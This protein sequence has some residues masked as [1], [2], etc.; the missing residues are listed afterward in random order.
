M[1]GLMYHLFSSTSLLSLGLFHLVSSA[2]SHLKSPQ[3]Y[4]ARPYH[5]LPF[6]DHHHRPFVRNLQLY[7]LV[8]FLL[9]AAAI[10]AVS[11]STY[12][13]L[14]KGHS[15]V[16]RFTSL[17][18]SA[19]LLL[20]L[21][22]PLSILLSDSL[23]SLLPPFPPDLA[24]ALA[25]AAFYLLSSASSS[26]AAAQTSDLEAK[27]DSLSSLIS[28][29]SS[30]LCLALAVNPKLFVADL[31]L[32]AS[33]CLQ[34]LWVLQTGLSLYVEAFIP[35]GCHR[36]LDVA[37]GV[38]GSTKC[39]LEE[40]KLRATAILDLVFTI[41]VMFVVIIVLVIYAAVAKSVGVRRLGSY[42][43]LPT[44]VDRDRET[45]SHIQMKSLTGTQ[46]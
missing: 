20:F 19:V 35:E 41:H 1:A 36:L 2:R 31:G 40:S 38:E 10:H 33:V 4:S 12:D 45:N 34:G 18:S 28:A 11:S 23:P 9:V 25:S 22:L 24:F 7:L 17:H 42:E 15:A 46:A 16:H 37:K 44:I 26:S 13:P 39:D 3:S 8:F 5:P 29:L 30:L 14:L 43:P 27:C 32:G 6:N 21:L